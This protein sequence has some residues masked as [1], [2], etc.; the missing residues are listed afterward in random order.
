[1]QEK[2]GGAP[3]DSLFSL[4]LFFSG[5]SVAQHVLAHVFI[6]CKKG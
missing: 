1:M 5:L 6:F 4:P 3:N 2:E